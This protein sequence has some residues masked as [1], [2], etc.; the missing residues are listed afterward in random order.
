MILPCNKKRVSLLLGVAFALL[1][2]CGNADEIEF[3]LDVGNSWVYNCTRLDT[4]YVHY[5]TSLCVQQ[6]PKVPVIWD[7]KITQIV[8]IDKGLVGATSWFDADEVPFG[9]A[10]TEYSVLSG[11]VLPK[12]FDLIS[13]SGAELCHEAPDSVRHL[14]IRTADV[15][16]G[17][18]AIDQTG[19]VL[20]GVGFD[21]RWLIFETDPVLWIT[22]PISVHWETQFSLL[23][24]LGWQYNHEPSQRLYETPAGTFSIDTEIFAQNSEGGNQYTISFSRGFGFVSLSQLELIR[25]NI[26]G[27]SLPAYT[28]VEPWPWWKLKRRRW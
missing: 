16:Q 19:L 24:C 7:L 22:S 18:D 5:G 13:W 6:D 10:G 25:A 20:G 15:E 21:D 12:L 28:N 3:P 11:S 17:A 14:A 2:V 1:G 27:R 4:G 26:G 9:E 23:N 8:R